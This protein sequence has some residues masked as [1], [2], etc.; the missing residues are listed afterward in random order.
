[1]SEATTVVAFKTEQQKAEEYK[2]KLREALECAALVMTDAQR[3]GLRLNFNIGM[4][5]FGRHVITSI[6]CIK[7]L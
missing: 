1:M 5:A 2:C 4:D 7:P 3:D 6:E